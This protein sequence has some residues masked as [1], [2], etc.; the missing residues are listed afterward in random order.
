MLVLLLNNLLNECGDNVKVQHKFKRF[1][2]F[3]FRHF[4]E[5]ITTDQGMPGFAQP[6]SGILPMQVFNM[7]NVG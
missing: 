3:Q 7:H 2:D 4:P 5:F 6:R 1:R